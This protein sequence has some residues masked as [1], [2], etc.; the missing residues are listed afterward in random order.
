MRTDPDS[1]ALSAGVV[2]KSEARR[3]RLLQRAK[4]RWL[5]SWIDLVFVLPLVVF[6]YIAFSGR[7]TLQLET[8]AMVAVFF[9]MVQWSIMRVT[10]RLNS[11]IQFLLEQPPRGDAQQDT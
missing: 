2:M 1:K 6:C 5:F 11:L 3:A 9:M 10:M 7:R 8:L 4:G